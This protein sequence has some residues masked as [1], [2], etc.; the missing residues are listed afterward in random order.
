MKMKETIKQ[1]NIYDNKNGIT[2]KE[3]NNKMTVINTSK[4]EIKIYEQSVSHV[5]FL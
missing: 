4:K 2:Q 3:K 5:L 1:N